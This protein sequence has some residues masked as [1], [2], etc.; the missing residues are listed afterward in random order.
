[1]KLLFKWLIATVAILIAAYLVPGVTIT[2]TG[3]FVAAVVLGALNLTIRPI[4]LVLTF[5]IT[6][7]TLGAFSLVINAFLVLLTAYLV[8][9]FA[10][11]GFWTALFFALVLAIVNWVFNF[12]SGI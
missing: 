1:M 4:L 7:I 2:T 8:P 12:W 10:L 11:A 6:V 9:G 5:P 3:A